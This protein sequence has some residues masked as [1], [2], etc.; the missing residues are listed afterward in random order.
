LRRFSAQ[1]PHRRRYAKHHGKRN[2]IK[3]PGASITLARRGPRR[4]HQVTRQHAHQAVNHL[5]LREAHHRA[6]NAKPEHRHHEQAP[7]H[8]MASR[9]FAQKHSDKAGGQSHSPGND[10]QK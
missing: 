6:G 5:V 9:S 2:A 8:R 3:Q 7:H 4:C 10:V 1:N